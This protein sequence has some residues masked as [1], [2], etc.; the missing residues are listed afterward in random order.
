MKKEKINKKADSNLTMLFDWQKKYVAIAR[1]FVE[2]YKDDANI[3]GITLNGGVSRGTGDSFSEVDIHFYVKDEKKKNLPIKLPKMGNDIGINGVWF[4]IYLKNYKDYLKKK[5]GMSERWDLANSKIL[6]DRNN[7]VKELIKKKA[8]WRK[9]EKEDLLEEELGFGRFWCFLLA[10]TFVQR[11][12]VVNAH[13][14][15]NKSL[16]L[17]VDY[18]FVKSNQ[19]IPHF[20]WKY[21]YFQKLKN[22]PNKIKKAIFEAYKITDYSEKDLKRR[23]SIMKGVLIKNIDK[24]ITQQSYKAVKNFKNNLK[25]GIFYHCHFNHKKIK[26]FE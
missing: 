22:P 26:E 3:I 4:D 23:M 16:D 17:F 12:D 10:R 20:K 15:L 11:E 19:F 9:R 6:L 18:Y 7:K 13:M 21:Y 8:R 25:Q 2:K 5:L 1:S 24:P 14:L